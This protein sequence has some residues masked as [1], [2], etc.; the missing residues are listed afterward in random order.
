MLTLTPS[1][2]FLPVE[3]SAVLVELGTHRPSPQGSHA[4]HDNRIATQLLLLPG[5]EA[6]RSLAALI[7]LD[8]QTLGRVEALVC[9]WRGYD[10][11]PVPPD[12]RMTIP[13]RHERRQ[14]P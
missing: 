8:S 1:P 2:D 14:L 6:N 5:S 9:F 12:T 11:R 3:P 13:Q 7:P 4:V 10:K